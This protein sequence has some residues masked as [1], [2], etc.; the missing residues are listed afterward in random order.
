MAVVETTAIF[1]GTSEHLKVNSSNASGSEDPNEAGPTLQ[2]H[3]EQPTVGGA[4]HP[5]GCTPCAFYCFKRSGCRKGE[6]C[7]YCH[8]THISKERQRKD[9]WKKGQREKRSRARTQLA[10]S[11]ASTSEASSSH[12]G[13]AE[14]GGKKRQE[15][16]VFHNAVPLQGVTAPL[17]HL[18]NAVATA[19]LKQTVP[20]LCRV[21]GTKVSANC[22]PFKGQ[23]YYWCARDGFTPQWVAFP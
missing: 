8:M 4:S 7:M 18:V 16:L 22:P 9:K 10:E 11:R 14:T 20:K 5:N 23:Q 15:K 6:D 12:N 21:P 2:S 13:D 3:G 1:P 19:E 17:E